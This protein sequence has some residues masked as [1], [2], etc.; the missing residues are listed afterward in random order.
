MNENMTEQEAV[1]LMREHFVGQWV[2]KPKNLSDKTV[3]YKITGARVRN[4]TPELERTPELESSDGS[5]LRPINATWFPLAEYE[6]KALD[7]DGDW[8]IT[9]A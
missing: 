3:T 6:E 5:K 1:E 9:E 2:E 4:G 7:E 8:T